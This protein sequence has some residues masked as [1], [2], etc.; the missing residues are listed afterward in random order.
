MSLG[1]DMISNNNFDIN[2]F[3]KT[4]EYSYNAGMGV[5]QK[6]PGRGEKGPD[7]RDSS[8]AAGGF[9]G[10]QLGRHLAVHDRHF[11]FFQHR[12]DPV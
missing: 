4:N 1:G 11:A 12:I 10:H 9:A 2:A 8:Q 6:M 3:I 5:K 7:G